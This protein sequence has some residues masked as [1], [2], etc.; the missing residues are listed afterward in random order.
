MDKFKAA[1]QSELVV[2]A[3]CSLTAALQGYSPIS[4][5]SVLT[6]TCLVVRSDQ[7]FGED[8]SV[9][10]HHV[11]I[12]FLAGL[13]VSQHFPSG[14]L[15][16]L[17]ILQLEE[18]WKR[19]ELYYIAVNRNIATTYPDHCD[20][21]QELMLLAKIHSLGIRGEA[22]PH[23]LKQ[24]ILSLYGE[25]D[26]W[27]INTLGFTIGDALIAFA[28][29]ENLVTRRWQQVKSK[30][31]H[32]NESQVKAAKTL[33]KSAEEALGFTVGELSA[34]SG[35]AQSTCSSLMNRLS[36][37]FGYHNVQNPATFSDPHLS[38]WDYNTLYERPFVHHNGKY[39]MFVPP[40]VLTAMFK[41]FWFDLH[42][43]KSYCNLFSA[44]NG[45]WLEREAAQRLT[46]VF[47]TDAVFLS[48][49][50]TNKSEDEVSDVL[51]IYDRNLLIVQ[52]KAKGLRLESRVGAN[53]EALVG[54]LRK[55]VGQ[56]F[57]QGL[58]ARDYLFAAEEVSILHN[59]TR[60]SINSNLITNVLLLTVNP[61]PL[62]FLTTR[63][64]NNASV[65]DL[66]RSNELPWALSLPDLDILTEILDTP[67]LF[68]HYARKRLKIEQASANYRGDEMDLLGL[69]IDGN[70]INFEG[71][72]DVLISGLS[73][74]ID[75]YVWR[76]YEL[77][78]LVEPP[79]PSISP[80]FDVLI[81]DILATGC[82]GR[83]DCAI[84]LL[85]LSAKA[86]AELMKNI[87][88]A[89]SASLLN[90]RMQRLSANVEGN[91]IGLIHIV[92]NSSKDSKDLKMILKLYA[93]A[94]KYVEKLST[95]IA[96]A[97]DA[98]SRST[99]DICEFLS[100]PWK[101]DAELNKLAVLLSRKKTQQE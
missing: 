82:E 35:L 60:I 14:D 12:E 37:D 87:S 20:P 90:G 63:I 54:D 62:Q 40:L 36:Q 70:L 31:S 27:F 76:K 45:R 75:K 93:A 101:E 77:E 94:H 73:E 34:A 66:F 51:V 13:L 58:V 95:C 5:L 6:M 41:T 84:A 7:F 30:I 50:K 1:E 38:P 96:M 2:D 64:A 74:S 52:C 28:A 26:A 86:Q 22:H 25:H 53:I 80:E 100:F 59:G 11:Y 92:L 9:H 29:I 19:L 39:F 46:Q 68:L 8:S 57:D 85:D 17:S 83:T 67:L 44:A 98:N 43:D 23:Q 10:Q 91:G 32:E 49:K 21:A 18:I 88:L 89:K 47:G 61:L 71:Y 99:I 65:R 42:A 15:K 81:S 97:V 3:F 56:A 69:H 48:P 33:A 55:A 72:T 4:I 16:D 79:R 78:E 24:M